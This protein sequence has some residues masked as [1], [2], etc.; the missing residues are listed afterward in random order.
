MK[1]LGLYIHIPFCSAKCYYCD[2]ISFPNMEDC[3]NQYIDALISEALLY[4][5]YLNSKIVDTIFIGGGT[6]SLFSPLQ[7]KRLLCG[8]KDVCN[9]EAK[10]ITIEANPET[11]NAQ[12]IEGFAACGINRLS[13]GLQ[14]HD[15]DILKRIGRRHTY[16]MFLEAINIAKSYFS[17]ISVD[18]IFA[19]PGQS[20]KSF[21]ETIQN[22]IDLSLQH[23]SAYALKLEP[24]TKLACDFAGAD[25]DTDRQM[26]HSA[27]KLLA[28]AGYDHYET[29]NFAKAGFECL[30]NLKYW[31]GDEY[32]GLGAAAHSFTAQSKK[33]RSSNTE[34]INDYFKL[35]SKG[36]RPAAQ[37]I[38]LSS[39]DEKNEYLMLRLRLKKGISFKDFNERFGCDFEK[40]F[41]EPIEAALKAGLITR[42]ENG[43]YPTLRGFDLQNTC[44]AEFMKKL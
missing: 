13:M 16:E 4:Q 25:E 24:G 1:K 32:L 36:K 21:I 33:V 23:I 2:F 10:E 42:D 18:T 41:E 5:N 35:I 9:I 6:P 43:I 11:L 15:N 37:T 26:Y 12:K 14:T 39:L 28:S 20:I 19:L 30:H 7:I 40:I 29:S 31:N 22:L 44:I 34:V 3:F 8:L 38:S 27:V 17:N